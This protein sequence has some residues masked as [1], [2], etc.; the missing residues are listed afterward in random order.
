MLYICAWYV[1][2]LMI[3]INSFAHVYVYMNWFTK[4]LCVCVRAKC[5]HQC[6][7]HAT[8]LSYHTLPHSVLKSDWVSFGPTVHHDFSF[9][10]YLLPSWPGIASYPPALMTQVRSPLWG[11]LGHPLSIW[12]YATSLSPSWLHVLFS[13]LLPSM[14]VSYLRAGFVSCIE[15]SV[16]APATL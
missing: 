8:L 6:L 4:I 12:W 9:S 15:H 2:M 11:A 1:H 10:L 13:Y 3:H 7:A 16:L 5:L 14:T